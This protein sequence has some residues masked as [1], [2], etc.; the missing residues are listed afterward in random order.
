MKDAKV[1]V[2][3]VHGDIDEVVPVSNTHA[4]VDD[5][6]ELK[7]R[8]VIHLNSPASR[9]VRSSNLASSPSYEFFAKQKKKEERT[10]NMN[11]LR[12]NCNLASTTL[13]L[14]A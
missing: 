6:K 7:M 12:K 8:D 2:I 14:V 9:T 13:A 11:T 3:I 5:M 10:R 4:W 1:P